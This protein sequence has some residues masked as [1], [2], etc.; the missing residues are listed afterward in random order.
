MF[1]TCLTIYIKPRRKCLDMFA[2]VVQNS[3]YQSSFIYKK[4]TV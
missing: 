4:K 2:F 1:V 3:E